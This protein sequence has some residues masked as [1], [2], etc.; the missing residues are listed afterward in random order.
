MI[1]R[2]AALAVTVIIVV[3]CTAVTKEASQVTLYKT[4][5]S[6][7][8]E[9]CKRLGPVTGSGSGW[10]PRLSYDSWEGVGEDAKNALRTNAAKKYGADAVMLVGLDKQLTSV[11]AQGVAYKCF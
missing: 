10:K 6:N 11:V 7:A 1:F 4:S 8:L 5:Q 2:T 9:E 3:G